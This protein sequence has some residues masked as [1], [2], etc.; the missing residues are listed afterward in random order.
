MSSDPAKKN[1]A[2]QISPL[3]RKNA[4]PSHPI[5]FSVVYLRFFSPFVIPFVCKSDAIYA[6]HQYPW[7]ISFKHSP[8]E[9]KRPPIRAALG[10][11]FFGRR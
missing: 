6:L 9:R 1:T 8:A 4:K 2:S 5:R 11:L 3:M 7:E 10:D